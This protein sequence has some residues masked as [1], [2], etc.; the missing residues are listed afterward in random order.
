MVSKMFIVVIKHFIL[1]TQ[2][3]QIIY[4][5]QPFKLFNNLYIHIYLN[6]IILLLLWW[7]NNVIRHLMFYESIVGK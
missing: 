1:F 7:L 3:I 6:I 2:V 4:K 5:L